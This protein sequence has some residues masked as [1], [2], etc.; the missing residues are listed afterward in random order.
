M[1]GF[2]NTSWTTRTATGTTDT[3]LATDYVVIYTNTSAKTV[4]LPAAATTQPGRAY[5]VI[6]GAAGA[7]TVDASGSETIN[8]ATTL[9]V[10]ATTGRAHLI[11]DGTQWWTISSS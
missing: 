8:G 10:T 2:D 6:N 7:I 9:A 4:N 11:S 3:L 1:S 5:I